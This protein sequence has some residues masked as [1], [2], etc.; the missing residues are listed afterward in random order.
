MERN[1]LRQVEWDT[2]RRVGGAPEGR[3]NGETQR[4]YA[5]Y[6]ENEPRASACS[7][8]CSCRATCSTRAAGAAYQELRY[9]TSGVDDLIS[10]GN[11]PV[12]LDERV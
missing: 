5:Y 7:R 12:Q 10:R 9:L 4:L 3:I 11:G 2:N 1:S 6:R 8:G